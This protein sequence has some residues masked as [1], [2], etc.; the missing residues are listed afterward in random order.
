[1]KTKK[2]IFTLIELL[3]VIAIIAVLASMLLPALGKAKGRAKTAACVN[4]LK[5]L[6]TNFLFYANDYDGWLMPS[7]VPDYQA[8]PGLTSAHWFKMLRDGMKV[9][10]WPQLYGCPVVPIVEA[11]QEEHWNVYGMFDPRRDSVNG[12]PFAN[13]YKGG[14]VKTAKLIKATKAISYLIDKRSPKEYPY[15]A[16]T[17]LYTSGR[18]TSYQWYTYSEDSGSMGKFS[19]RHANHGNVWFPD[20][21]ATAMSRREFIY[22][23]NSHYRIVGTAD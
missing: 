1:M 11:H 22:G 5:Q 9:P 4:N 20:G 19:L 6:G 7:Y 2:Q 10:G 12:A 16:D 23:T 3:V 21:H 15:L 8:Y 13:P 14:K 18:Y 17:Q